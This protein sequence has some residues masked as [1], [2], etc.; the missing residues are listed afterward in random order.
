MEATS[1]LAAPVLVVG[2]GAVGFCC[3]LRLLEAGFKDV[4]LIAAK[5]SGIPSKTTAGIFRPDY[6]GDTDPV[7]VVQWGLE[8][9]CHLQR[10]HRQLGSDSGIA[11]VNHQEVYHLEGNPG[12]DDPGPILPQVMPG[13]RP[14]TAFELATHCPSADGGWS[15]TSFVVEGSRYLPW[16]QER[17]ESLGLRVIQQ[18][19]EGGAPGTLAFCKAAAAIAERPTCAVTVVNACG[20]H[21]GPECRNVRGQFV[22]VDAPYVK[23]ALG[24]YSPRDR[25]RPTYIIPRRGHVV[26]GCTYLYDD[27]DTEVRDA[28]STDIVNRC[29]EFVP[30]LK[31]ARVISEVV[32]L[33][34]GR[35]EG[36]RLDTSARVGRFTVVSCY[37]HGG[38]GISLAWGCAG[39]VAQRVGAAATAAA[40]MGAAAG[41]SASRL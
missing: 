39:E 33:R 19:V 34:P 1:P 32:C 11:C 9:R 12:A 25:T 23:I 16:L 6:L 29:A 18:K 41:T 10:L 2:G 21:G 5:F 38:A 20:V 36:V 8:T 13:F 37:G 4:T 26:L 28:T 15:Y 35:K 27:N 17:A 14:M 40:A 30:E 31:T 7:R 3:A 22:L 24:E